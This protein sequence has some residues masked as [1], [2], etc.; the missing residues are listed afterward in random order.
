MKTPAAQSSLLP[1]TAPTPHPDRERLFDALAFS[2]APTTANHLIELLGAAGVR[3]LRGSGFHNAEVR[4]VLDELAGLGLAARDDRGR[5]SAARD[6]GWQRFRALV[7]DDADRER[8][9]RAWR[10]HRHFDN[11][12]RI[13]MF[14][15]ASVAG[16][17]RVVIHCGCNAET[18]N[19]LS[20]LIGPSPYAADGLRQALLEPFDAELL[21]R[22]DLAFACALAHTLLKTVADD[23]DPRLLPLLDWLLAQ[24]RA[25]P[26]KVPE[27]LHY[28]LAERL[29]FGEQFGAARELLARLATPEAQAIGAG[30]DIAQGRYADGSARFEAACKALA[31]ATGKRKNLLP[32]SLAWL[33]TMA[34]LSR[35]EPAAWIKARKFAAAESGKREAQPYTFWG[36]WQSAIDQRLGDSPLNAKLFQLAR[37]A[38]DRYHDALA[39]LQHLLLAAWLRVE[40]GGR[41]AQDRLREHAAALEARL[42]NANALWLARLARRAAAQLLGQTPDAADSAMPFFVGAAQ[43]RWREALASIVALGHGPVGKQEAGAQGDRL[44][45]AVTVDAKSHRIRAI[46]PLEQKA[47]ARGLGKAKPVTLVALIKRK[48]LP[49][50]DAA[51][52]RAVLREDYGNRPFL[53]LAL[54][55]AAL[56]R[57]P[58]VAWAS[59]P[60]R[61]IEV[62]ESL[63]LLEVM[64]RGE[65]IAFRLVDPLLAPADK[66]RRSDD[67][68]DDDDDLDSYLS[69]RERSTEERARQ[70]LLI[71]DGSDRARLVRTTPA[72][73]RVAELVTQGWQVPAGE[74]TELDAALRVLATH[75]QIASDA[76]AGQEVPASDVLRAE[77]APR[78]SGIELKLVAAPFG[79]FGPRL[80]PG[81]GR[82]RVT[83]VHQGATLYTRRAID[84]ER[85][86]FAALLQ[87]AEFLDDGAH[88]WAIDEPGQALAVVEALAALAPGIVSEWPKGKPLRV[89]PVAAHAVKLVVSSGRGDWLAIDGELAL[90]DGEV[91]RLRALLE[92]VG[93]GK[94]RYVA[95]GDG[96]FIALSDGLRQQL[97][98]LNAIAQPP[99]PGQDGQRVAPIAALAWSRQ[100]G[101]LQVA[102]DAA[103]RRRIDAWTDAQQR[104]FDTP[105]T[106][107]A[108]LRD[109]QQAG[110]H[111]LMRLAA[112]GFGACLADDMGLGKTL[113]TLAVLLERAAG[114]AA[115]VVAP[116]SVCS[117]WLAEAARFAPSLEMQMY[118]DVGEAGESDLADEETGDD[119]APDSAPDS[120]PDSMPD[121]APDNAR[122]AARRRQLRALGPGQVLLCSYGLLQRDAELLA[123]R[124]W[125]SAVLDEAQAIKNAATR[126][127]KAAQRIEADFRLALTGTPIENRL[128]E[129][130]SIM[131]FANPG[132][133][134]S[135]EQFA[136]R[137]ALP[138]ERDGDGAASRRL[139]RLVAPFLLR[140][141]K[142]EV[143][144]DLPPRTEIVHEVVPGK[145]ERALLE[146]LRQQAE[147]SVDRVV[148]EGAAPGQAQI[149]LLAALTRLRRAACD[150]RL[151]A[152]E[153]GLV[154][155]K[156]QEFERL[157][158]E[159]VAGRHKAL[160]FSQFT[161]FLA[162]LRERLDAA[163]LAYQYLDGST[164]AAERGKR[165][166][167]FQQGSGDLFLISLKAGGFGLNLTVADY[168]IIADPWWNPAAEDQASGRAH[169][170][171]QLRPVTVYRLVTQGSIED[172]IVRLHRSK[173]ELA[174]G[175]LGG[176]DGG[177]A[178]DA[179]ALLALLR[180]DGG[181][182]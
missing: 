79:D 61:F 121:G 8:W 78:G 103:W 101:E 71:A 75:F 146:V 67:D 26:K 132:L 10:Q 161:D 178:M 34:L 93:S 119:A 59:D 104:R 131:G 158:L 88:E 177:A 84:A 64:T 124:A 108:E 98:D 13:E 57:H 120:M 160:V 73:L 11:T 1:D 77:L 110:Y 147:D 41:S 134:G 116:T 127:A 4:R 53:D 170:I 23:T 16:A 2:Q 81:A 80:A 156:V 154:G 48:D 20:T 62:V 92:L 145:R 50:H 125:H 85:A 99:K 22:L 89:R 159:L 138:I 86:H 17:M 56:V 133:L 115:L 168:V 44:I 112:S 15:S 58:H 182:G 141:T 47:S 95:L 9:W 69:P 155:A 172:R 137:F 143:L 18:F 14:D 162:L 42:R 66:K 40:P 114:G 142:G 179:G 82:E 87:A 45:W 118:G 33:Y 5:W 175:I 174:E 149:H 6:T 63:P 38:N 21:G 24:A 36:L 165:V 12:W 117:N 144:T 70:T 126:R 29:L 76:E 140:R 54:A 39:L 157:A 135:A 130:W 100:S 169:R 35:S 139:R 90:D 122:L 109:Y 166:A 83:T 102:G 123:G 113:M 94:S 68:D 51:V 176:Q 3:T 171:G 43:D 32:P 129:L 27:H 72:Q 163:G 148:A 19:R 150:P 136:Q 181:A 65:H 180:G 164:P 151:V 128:G 60:Q 153:L 167:A 106:L 49:T 55:A 152:P 97:A 30:I 107:Q 173:R 46:E 52:L 105:G 74:K 28:R 37:S 7:S 111:W 25:T 91:L 31:A 96:D